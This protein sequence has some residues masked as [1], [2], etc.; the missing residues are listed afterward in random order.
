MP[1][2][3]SSFP[4]TTIGAI[5]VPAHLT[6]T[7]LASLARVKADT[8]RTLSLLLYVTSYNDWPSREI[9]QVLL[10]GFNIAD[11]TERK[12]P[13]IV[14]VREGEEGTPNPALIVSMERWH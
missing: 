10:F 9:A 14:R 6:W 7:F 3:T 12:S 8:L 5:G 1:A 2:H 13:V 11:S 4:S